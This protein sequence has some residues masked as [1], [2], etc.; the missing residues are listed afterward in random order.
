MIGNEEAGSADAIDHEVKAVNSS[1]L[2]LVASEPN[3]R[4][5]KEEASAR[6]CTQ[7]KYNII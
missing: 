5:K 4:E 3:R 6:L 2:A 1:S 7:V